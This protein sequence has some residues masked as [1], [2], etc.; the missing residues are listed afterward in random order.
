MTSSFNRLMTFIFLSVF[1]HM[2]YANNTLS[3][4]LNNF[5]EFEHQKKSYSIS[6]EQKNQNTYVFNPG[7]PKKITMVTLDWPPYI[8]KNICK[9]GWVQQFTIALLST[10]GYEITTSF[11]PWARAIILV[12]NGDV[13]VLYPEYFIEDSAPS[14]VIKGTQRRDHLIL[15]KKFIGGKIAFIKRSGEPSRFNGNLL[16]LKNERIGV[17]RGYQNTPAFDSLMDKGFFDISMAV[18]DFLNT[19]KLIAGRVDLIIGDPIVIFYSLLKSNLS[20]RGKQT[21][22][23][24]IEEVSPILQYNYLYF[25]VSRK[26]PNHKRILEDINI[27]I[28]EFE[29]TGMIHRLIQSVNH[30]CGFDMPQTSPPSP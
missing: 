11:L 1:L 23:S 28:D 9:Q 7:A 18:D 2:I 22:M 30:R 26:R 3:Q 14:D 16:S 20:T 24:K 15:S 8:G 5:I 6:W 21:M 19:K 25:A 13:D 10:R 12:E 29:N 17:V 27:G 4:E